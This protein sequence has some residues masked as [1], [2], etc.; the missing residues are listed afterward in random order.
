MKSLTRRKI[1]R[2]V[3]AMCTSLASGLLAACRNR[4]VEVERI[5][6]VEREVTKVVTEIVRETVIV[7]ST[8]QIVE[9]T[10]EKVVTPTPAPT[11][12]AIIVADVT[13]YGWSE[14]ATRMSPAFQEMFPQ[15]TVRWRGRYGWAQ[16]PQ[17][18]AALQASGQEGDLLEAPTGTLLAAWTQR[19]VIHPLDDLLDTEHFDMSDMFQGCVDACRYEGKLMALPFLC[20]AGENVLVHNRDSFAEKDLDPPAGDWTLRDLEQAGRQLTED[21]N[22]DGRLDRFGYVLQHQLPGAYPLLRLFDAHLFSGNGEAS[23]V[24]QENTL[25]LVRWL[26]EQVHGDQIAPRPA[27]IERGGLDMFRSGRAAMLRGDLRTLI[28]LHRMGEDAPQTGSTLLPVHPSTGKQGTAARGMTYAIGQAT[29]NPQHV[30]QWIRFMCSREM[31]VQMLLGGYAEPGCRAAS[32]KDPRVLERFPIC[33]QIAEAAQKAETQRLPWNLRTAECLS[34]WNKGVR[35]ILSD[36]V[37][38]EDGA[39]RI[40]RRIEEILNG[41]LEDDPQIEDW[42]M[43]LSG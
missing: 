39:E 7:E 13:D 19:G 40:E 33:S 35:A 15:I 28:T 3:A 31:G 26:H 10:V 24:T 23:A 43:S 34:V 5:I 16:Y 9:R 30:L 38:V 1:L 42:Q 12:R 11:P 21:T 29:D 14:F 22:Q 37:G 36:K 27:Q 2:G 32:W 17:R 25:S 41:P 4:I 6:R 18:I 8:P 20:H